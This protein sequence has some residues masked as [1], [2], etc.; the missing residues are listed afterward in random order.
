MVIQV[1]FATLIGDEVQPLLDQAGEQLPIEATAIEDHREALVADDLAYRGNHRRQ[2]LGQVAADLF[3]H[4]QQWPA[5]Q[6]VDEI[7]HDAWQWHAPVRIPHLR[8][9]SR[10]VVHLDVAVDVQVARIHQADLEPMPSEQRAQMHRLALL[11]ELVQLTTQRLDA[12]RLP[13]AHNRPKITAQHMFDTLNA[14]LLQQRQTKQFGEDLRDAKA[15]QAGQV[16]DLRRQ[17]E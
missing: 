17:L 5:A 15:H 2:A 6:I 14:R 13:T 16:V 12:G 10:A 3:G 7:L 1:H 9:Q 8:H 11:A 4:H